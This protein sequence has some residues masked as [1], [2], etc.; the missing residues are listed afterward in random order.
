MGWSG[1]DDLR[2]CVDTGRRRRGPLFTAVLLAITG[3]L[4]LLGSAQAGP[5]KGPRAA[6]T[7][8]QR[9]PCTLRA[10]GHVQQDEWASC[11]SV[12][13]SLSGAPAIGQPAQLTFTV[14][15]QRS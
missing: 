15:S 2:T 5:A 9:P 8:P 1:M 10:S 3:S 14:R 13:A 11:I 4:V 6:P 7:G 12:T